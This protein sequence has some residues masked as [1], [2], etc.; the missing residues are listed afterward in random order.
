MFRWGSF[1]SI[2]GHVVVE[3]IL[4]S[5]GLHSRPCAWYSDL[6]T[7]QFLIVYSK[8]IALTMTT[9]FPSKGPSS[10]AELGS[11][12]PEALTYRRIYSSTIDLSGPCQLRTFAPL[13]G[14]GSSWPGMICAA[15][16]S[17]PTALCA[18]CATG[19]TIEDMI[20]LELSLKGG[21]T[22]AGNSGEPA[23]HRRVDISTRRAPCLTSPMNAFVAFDILPEGGELCSTSQWSS[24]SRKRF[25]EA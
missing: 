3:V 15:A 21:K 16:N 4:K 24:Q 17:D 2:S 20:Q 12:D 13:P 14:F 19:A 23:Q 10:K 1:V 9:R 22:Q 18:A 5:R 8:S 11:A 6:Y 25:K 7:S